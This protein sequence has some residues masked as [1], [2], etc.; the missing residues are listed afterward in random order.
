MKKQLKLLMFASEDQ[1]RDF[2][3]DIDFSDF[4][5]AADFAPVLMP[6]LQ[7]SSRSQSKQLT[8]QP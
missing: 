5:E 7:P 8:L 4:A 2:W 1:E 6:N 3:S